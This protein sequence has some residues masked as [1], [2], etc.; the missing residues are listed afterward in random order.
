MPLAAFTG[1]RCGTRNGCRGW[2][3][4]I[5]WTSG[6][7]DLVFFCSC[8]LH[9]ILTFH[10]QQ[11]IQCTTAVHDGDT[12]ECIQKIIVFNKLWVG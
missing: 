5:K 11:R 2:G 8:G 4:R 7:V 10:T 9:L 12:N 6:V 3:S 1:Q